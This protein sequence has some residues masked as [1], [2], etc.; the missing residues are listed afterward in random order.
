MKT[1]LCV[2]SCSTDEL[3]ASTPTPLSPPSLTGRTSSVNTY[4]KISLK[5]VCGLTLTLLC[6]PLKGET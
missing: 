5:W 1:H 6:S 4:L 2:M 3:R